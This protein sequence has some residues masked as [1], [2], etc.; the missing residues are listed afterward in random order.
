MSMLR[1]LLGLHHVACAEQRL[2]PAF[3]SLRCNFSAI[4]ETKEVPEGHAT[5]DLSNFACHIGLGRRRDL[6]LRQ[7]LRLWSGQGEVTLADVF[8]V[9]CN[10]ERDSEHGRHMLRPTLS[11]G[12]KVMLIGMPGG[13]VCCD[14]HFPSYLKEV[15]CSCTYSDTRARPCGHARPIPVNSTH[16]HR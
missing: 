11:Q 14:F 8:K 4:A 3:A 16:A 6:T 2:A 5:S 10:C 7:D 15:S 9:T 13:K 12:K 1:G